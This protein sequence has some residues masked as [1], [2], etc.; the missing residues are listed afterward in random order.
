[1]VCAPVRS[2][3][4]SLKLGDFLSVQAHK[5]CFISHLY[6][7]FAKELY[8]MKQGNNYYLKNLSHLYY[9]FILV[10]VTDTRISQVSAQVK[11]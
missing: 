10:Q 1:M 3:I 6:E 11:P 7:K 4:P 9:W 2:I 5:L 8:I